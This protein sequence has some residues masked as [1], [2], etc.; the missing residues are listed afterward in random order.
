MSVGYR[1][2]LHADPG[3]D[4]VD[5]VIQHLRQWMTSKDIDVP[6]DC[7]GKYPLANGNVITVVDERHAEGRVYRW[8]RR[9]HDAYPGEVLCTTITA[10]EGADSSGWLWSEIE[11]R[12]NPHSTDPRLFPCMSVP[13]VL[14]ALMG[15]LSFRD[16]RTEVA[17][18]PQ[19]VCSRHLPD[20]MDYLAD[21]SRLGSIY[22]ASQ[23]AVPQERFEHWA[24]EVTWNLVGM[25]S[26]LLLDNT[27]TSEFNEMVG[28]HHA[29]PVGTMRTYLPNVDLDDPEDPYRHR[30]LGTAR[31]SLTAPRRLAGMLGLAARVR[32]AQA[33]LPPDVIGLH[34]I[35]LARENDAVLSSNRGSLRAIPPAGNASQSAV[36]AKLDALEHEIQALRAALNQQTTNGHR[37]L[38]VS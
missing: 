7:P 14:R 29:V 27:V 28:E 2:F 18:E 10:I 19:W 32:A 15:V 38:S 16:G 33:P 26:V 36:L 6:A 4:L 17:A 11:T 37:H 34:Q 12:D 25:G 20:V 21:E 35:L 5:V 23:G 31:I 8:T 1:S 24:T 22:V 9:H 13:R 3:Q 30:I